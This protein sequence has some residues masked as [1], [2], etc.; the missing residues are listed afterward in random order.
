[1]AKV[2]LV[3]ED[4]NDGSVKYVMTSDGSQDLD[5]E[6][7]QAELFGSTMVDLL[8][9]KKIEELSADMIQSISKGIEDGSTTGQ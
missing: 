5:R 4:Q 2:T 3:L 9:T 8:V 7:T 6:I 1:M